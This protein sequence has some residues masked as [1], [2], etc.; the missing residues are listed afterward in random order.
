MRRKASR[1]TKHTKPRGRKKPRTAED[2]AVWGYGV[3]WDITGS[4]SN[5]QRR[6]FSQ[7]IILVTVISP[8]G[9]PR[10]PH[11]FDRILNINIHSN[12]TDVD[13]RLLRICILSYW[14]FF[15]WL[16]L[17]ATHEHITNSH[18]AKSSSG[19]SPSP[20]SWRHIANPRTCCVPTP[21]WTPLLG[22]GGERGRVSKRVRERKSKTCK[23]KI[24]ALML[25]SLPYGARRDSYGTNLMG[26]RIRQRGALW[27]FY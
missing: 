9:F 7:R 6:H 14:S 5:L 23:R 27:L 11:Q 25:T 20:P 16:C 8:V 26:S 17:N 19:I 15:F 18:L 22:W 4:S 12:T 21:I 2:H 13:L 24:N 10:P 3:R 1:N